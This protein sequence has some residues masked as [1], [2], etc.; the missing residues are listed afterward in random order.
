MKLDS[1]SVFMPAYNEEG[2]I[3]AAIEK[4]FTVLKKLGLKSYEVLVVNDGSTDK[5]ET[6]VK[7]FI[8]KYPQLRMITHSP[9]K[10][11]GEALKTGFYNCKYNYIVFIDSDGQ[12]DFAEVTKLI[13]KIDQADMVVGYRIDRKDPMFRKINGW[14]WTLLANI[15]F[16][17]SI[18][19]VDCAFKLT[20]KQVIDSIPHLE[21]TR[22][23]MISPELLARTKNSGFTIAEVGVHHFPR[24]SGKQTGS[25]LKVI[26][27][28]F[29]DLFRLW[30]KI[31]VKAHMSNLKTASQL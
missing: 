30:W 17:I 10:G 26:I 19:D 12:F 16:G 11:Y 31:K 2:N 27:R 14:G 24:E 6:I 20:K 15:L 13:D 5:T 3:G 23:G 4:I 7:K 21:S 9:N 8:K 22:G 28:S 1:L 25:N 18:R 29:A